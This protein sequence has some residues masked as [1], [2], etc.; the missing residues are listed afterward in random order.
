MPERLGTPAS[1]NTS[2]ILQLLQGYNGM[3][4]DERERVHSVCLCVCTQIYVYVSNLK[5]QVDYL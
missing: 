4:E 1:L 3:G 2:G 5:L